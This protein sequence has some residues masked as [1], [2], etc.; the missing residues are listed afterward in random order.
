MDPED[1]LVIAEQAISLDMVSTVLDPKATDSAALVDVK[2]NLRASILKTAQLRQEIVQ[3]K[4][5]FKISSGLYKLEEMY[6]T[7]DEIASR[8]NM[9]RQAAIN[10]I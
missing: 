1:P 2:E 7:R 5:E 3:S 10:R 4:L 8:N 6:D 9:H